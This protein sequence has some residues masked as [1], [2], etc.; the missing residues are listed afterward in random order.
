MLSGQGPGGATN[1]KT[2]IILLLTSFSNQ[3]QHL[4]LTFSN[5]KKKHLVYLIAIHETW[6]IGAQP[7]APALKT[8]ASEPIHSN[9]VFLKAFVQDTCHLNQSQNRRPIT[10]MESFFGYKTPK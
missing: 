8:F 9:W 2:S 3:D 10:N 1:I 6:K 4:N 7:M 5:L